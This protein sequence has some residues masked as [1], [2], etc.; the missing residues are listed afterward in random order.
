MGASRRA[1]GSLVDRGGAR[2]CGRSPSPGQGRVDVIAAPPRCQRSSPGPRWAARP[3]L[4]RVSKTLIPRVSSPADF[5]VHVDRLQGE[6]VRHGPRPPP[7]ARPSG[8]TPRSRTGSM[9]ARMPNGTIWRRNRHVARVRVRQ[10][11]QVARREDE[12]A[13]Q[14]RA[15]SG[16]IGVRRGAPAGPPPGRSRSGTRRPRSAFPGTRQ[17]PA[18]EDDPVDQGR[19][20]RVAVERPGQDGQPGPR[21]MTV[22]SRGCSRTRSTITL[23]PGWGVVQAWP[24]AARCRRGRRGRAAGC[25]PPRTGPAGRPRAAATCGGSIASMSSVDVL[26]GLV[27]RY[28][29]GRGDQAEDVQGRVVQ[30]QGDGERRVDARVGDEDDLLCHG[31]PVRGKRSAS[32]SGPGPPTPAGRC[33]G[34]IARA[35]SSTPSG[36]VRTAPATSSA[37]AALAR[38]TRRAG[39][40]SPASTPRITAALAAGPSA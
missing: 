6:R 35:A 2:T 25:R 23:S 7:R 17:R 27:G 4:G 29:P 32:R 12:L 24:A 39:P 30:G 5:H 15:G 22:T 3:G 28:V 36:S 31:C 38:T 19:Q 11:Q 1:R 18:Q 10:F 21:T 26:R 13:G 20:L 9:L 33:P 40:S 16:W 14:C 37:A 34:S 8:G